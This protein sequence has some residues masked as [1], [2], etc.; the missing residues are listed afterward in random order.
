MYL[1]TFTAYAF[2]AVFFGLF[3]AYKIYVNV[4]IL[5]IETSIGSSFSEP[6][7]TSWRLRTNKTSC[8]LLICLVLLM[9]TFQNI[10]LLIHQAK[11]RLHTFPGQ[12]ILMTVY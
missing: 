6:V 2:R 7:L 8:T 9:R 3:V 5:M 12:Y 4:M 1:L 10:G 11:T